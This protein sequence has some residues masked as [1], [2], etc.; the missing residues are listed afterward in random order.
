MGIGPRTKEGSYIPNLCRI[1]GEVVTDGPFNE[2]SDCAYTAALNADRDN[3]YCLVCD[4]PLTPDGECPRGCTESDD[5]YFLEGFYFG[6][7]L[8]D[9]DEPDEDWG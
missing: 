1:C 8:D 6:D 2:C 4:L 3:N 7:L 9:E 5:Y